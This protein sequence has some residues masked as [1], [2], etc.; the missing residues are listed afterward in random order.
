MDLFPEL[1]MRA[2][3]LF[4]CRYSKP[5]TKILLGPDVAEAMVEHL[6]AHKMFSPLGLPEECQTIC[7]IRFGY[8][9]APGVAVVK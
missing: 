7:G 8:M 3:T 4:R 5:P 6:K 9:L 2:L 1:P